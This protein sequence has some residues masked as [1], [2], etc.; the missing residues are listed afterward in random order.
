MN[1]LK[2][3]AFLSACIAFL[4]T[5]SAPAISKSLGSACLLAA[6]A[7]GYVAAALRGN[8]SKDLKHF[9]QEIIRN[10]REMGAAA[11]CSKY[12]AKDV[13]AELPSQRQGKAR[14][15]LEVGAGTGIVTK[16]FVKKL[17]GND[18]LDVVELQP[19]L[20]K[21]LHKKFGRIGGVKVHCT[22]IENFNPGKKYDAIVM[23]V[24]FNALPF[25]LVEKI[26]AHVINNLLAPGGTLSYIYYP[27][28]PALKKMTLTGE[29]KED[30]Q[31][32]QDHLNEL[33]KEHGIGDRIEIRNLPPVCTRYLRTPEKTQEAHIEQ[34]LTMKTALI[35]NINQNQGT[36]Y[37][38]SILA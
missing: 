4:H 18:T 33:Y 13:L 20:C 8:S 38:Q 3:I 16:R 7:A 30:F 15:F 22:G 27:G 35:Q 23:T 5:P 11:P 24:P 6:A 21:R 19:K 14:S 36:E 26:W 29:K 31:N 28:L 12:L 2:K 37:E 25:K 10:P 34:A 9:A 32:I 1:L 17:E